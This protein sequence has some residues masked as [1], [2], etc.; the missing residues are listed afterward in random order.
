MGTK[1]AV[2]LALCGLVSGLLTAFLMYP[3]EEAGLFCGATFG[4]F[5][6]VPLLLTG[7]LSN[8]LKAF[9]LIGLCVV[10]YFCSY[11]AGF[12]FQLHHPEFVAE[13][14]RWSMGTKEPPGPAGLLVGGLVGGFLVFY[15][16]MFLCL[17]AGRKTLRR[18]ALQGTLLGGALGVA[19]WALRSSV[20]VALWHLFHALKA[21][22]FWERS[23]EE[24][25]GGKL[26]YGELARM[27]SVY[28]V[29]QTGVAAAVGWMLRR[30]PIRPTRQ[31]GLITYL[32]LRGQ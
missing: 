18:K 22:P 10:A 4:V 30:E 26:D 14:E 25:F 23:P 31:G 15:S 16:V 1:L 19:G 7:L 5:L 2:I 3:Q 21:V 12:G 6:A 13:G 32:S 20:G 17:T 11:M 8:P 27:Y 29:W 24:W 9:G 28:V